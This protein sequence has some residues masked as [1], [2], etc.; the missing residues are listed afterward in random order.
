[1][2]VLRFLAGEVPEFKVQRQVTSTACSWAF[3]VIPLLIIATASKIGTL[4]KNAD[5]ER[6]KQIQ[7]LVFPDGIF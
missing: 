4:W 7:K 3:T 6:K 5:L 2:A 1:M